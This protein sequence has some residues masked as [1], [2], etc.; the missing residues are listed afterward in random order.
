MELIDGVPVIIRS[1]HG[2]ATLPTRINSD[3]RPGELF[4]TFHDPRVFLNHVTSPHRDSVVSA[5]EYKV[6]AVQVRKLQA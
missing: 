1:R 4:C 5:P 2:E 3:V 6:T